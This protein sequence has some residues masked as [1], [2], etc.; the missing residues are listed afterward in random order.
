MGFEMLEL[1]EHNVSSDIKHRWKKSYNYV[2][3]DECVDITK[4]DTVNDRIYERTGIYPQEAFV[5]ALK[6]Y[7][8]SD[9][10]IYDMKIIPQ[11][12]EFRLKERESVSKNA[13]LEGFVVGYEATE[14]TINEVCV[15]SHRDKIISRVVYSKYE[16]GVMVDYELFPIEK[17]NKI[18]KKSNLRK[19]HRGKKYTYELKHISPTKYKMA[20]KKILWYKDIN[21]ILHNGLHYWRDLEIYMKK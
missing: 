3:Y 10:K 13:I 19:K 12:K 18:P 21:T 7:G 20:L 6:F 4:S 2:D 16:S 5:D 15:E 17:I 9:D 8:F 14:E 1:V 11:I